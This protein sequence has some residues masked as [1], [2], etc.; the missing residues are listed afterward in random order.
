MKLAKK[1]KNTEKK[2]KRKIIFVILD[3]LA[4][5]GNETPL[6]RA[7][8]ENLDF[9]A[10]RGFC[11]LWQG[12]KAPKN[13]NPKS[14]SDVAT[15]EL[16]GYSWKDNPGRGFIEALGIGIKP[17]NDELYLRGNFATVEKIGKKFKIIDR[18][19]GRDAS[20]L[21]ELSK[22]LEMNIED[23]KIKC[24]HTIGHR[25]ILILEGKGLSTSI[26]DSDAEG[27]FVGNIIPKSKKAER[28]ARILNIFSSKAFEILDEHPLNKKRK[29]KANFLLLRGAGKIKSVVKFVKKYKLKACS[30]SGHVVIRGISRYLGI[31]IINVKG[32]N[33]ELNTNLK[34]KIDALEK[35]ID[36]YD[37]ILLHINGCDVAAHDKNFEA[38]K[39]FLE[40]I[41]EVVFSRMRKFRDI[42]LI[43]TSDHITSVASGKHEFG[44][45]PILFYSS[46]KD[47]ENVLNKFKKYKIA[48]RFDE[49]SCKHAMI[50]KNPMKFALPIFKNNK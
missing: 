19:A 27:D 25:C 8:K 31:D 47:L 34:G 37:F 16:L 50:I 39:R 5:I 33:A 3:G 45:V 9:F 42:N 4:D 36:K 6:S 7:K 10:S 24:L 32:A 13:Y 29:M 1:R 21:D 15:L 20:Y 22:S 49:I 43:V 35:A 41:D 38:K 30:I 28:T 26:T 44:E 46:E 23:V 11:C 48:K 17:K 40:K 2:N 18:R 14:M 12:A